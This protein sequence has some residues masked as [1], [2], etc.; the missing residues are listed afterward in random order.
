MPISKPVTLDMILR[1][2]PYRIHHGIF[3]KN[4]LGLPNGRCPISFLTVIM[5]MVSPQPELDV[6]QIIYYNNL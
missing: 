5:N 3:L 2:H 4:L 6:T 1:W